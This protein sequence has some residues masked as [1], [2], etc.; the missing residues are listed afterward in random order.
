[1]LKKKKDTGKKTHINFKKK[2]KERKKEAP[3]LLFQSL[4]C[5]K[6]TLSQGGNASLT[7]HNPPAASPFLPVLFLL[8]PEI[9]KLRHML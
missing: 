3:L 6:P 9:L 7:P 4:A 8:V 2:K 5:L 1:M